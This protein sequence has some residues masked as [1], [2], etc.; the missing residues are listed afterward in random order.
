MEGTRSAEIPQKGRGMGGRGGGGGCGV[1]HVGKVAHRK[2]SGQ[3]CADD[4]S[5][6]YQQQIVMNHRADLPRT[7]R[8]EELK[9]HEEALRMFRSISSGPFATDCQ[10]QALARAI[11]TNSEPVKQHFQAQ[12][13][14]TFLQGI[15][16]SK[17]ASNVYSFGFPNRIILHPRNVLASCTGRSMFRG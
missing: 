7:P 12:G 16:G 13:S 9:S 11:Q 1:W 2:W 15:V 3:N 6:D 17:M 14:C 5:D 8:I 4:D 10:P